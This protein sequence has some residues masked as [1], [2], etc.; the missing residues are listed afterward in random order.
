LAPQQRPVASDQQVDW[1]ELG[2]PSTCPVATR[3]GCGELSR[4]TIACAHHDGIFS[5]HAAMSPVTLSI[6]GPIL[7]ASKVLADAYKML[8]RGRSASQVQAKPAKKPR[9]GAERYLPPPGHSE[10]LFGHGEPTY[11]R[12]DPLTTK[13]VEPSGSRLKGPTG[14]PLAIPVRRSLNCET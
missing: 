9:L 11:S 10:P 7:H 3:L 5:H 2:L 1:K 6:S 4:R 13:W 12:F 8:Q 14:Q